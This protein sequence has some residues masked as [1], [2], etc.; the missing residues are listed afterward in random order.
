[1]FS[2]LY[3]TGFECSRYGREAKKGPG[4]GANTVKIHRECVF[5]VPD[6]AS[7]LLLDFTMFYWVLMSFT[8]FY[9]VLLGFTA[10]STASSRLPSTHTRNK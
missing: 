9:Y 5:Y 3:V 6:R 10:G 2:F 8:T 1:M 7:S 4:H